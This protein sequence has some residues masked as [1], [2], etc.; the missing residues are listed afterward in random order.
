MTR[1]ISSNLESAI[2]TEAAML[3][4]R[5]PDKGDDEVIEHVDFVFKTRVMD[6]DLRVAAIIAYEGDIDAAYRYLRAMRS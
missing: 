4:E 1:V 3:G 2:I 6:E 5:F